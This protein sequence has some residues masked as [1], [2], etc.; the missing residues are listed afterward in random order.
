[1]T[2]KIDFTSKLVRIDKES[3]YILVKKKIHQKDI[4]I[5]NLY[6]PHIAASNSWDK[7]TDEHKR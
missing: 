1:M 3:H 6:L 2:D 7:N 4:M 5:V